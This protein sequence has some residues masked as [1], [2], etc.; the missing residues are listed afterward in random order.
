MRSRLARLAVV[1]ALVGG[2]FALQG[3]Q[4]SGADDQDPIGYTIGSRLPSRGEP[5]LACNFYRIDLKTGAATQVNAVN[6][7]VPCGDGLTFDEDRTLYAYR[8]T[9]TAGPGVPSQLVTID[10]HTGAQT[11]VGQL[12]EV[13]VG[14]GGMTFDADGHLWLYGIVIGD[15]SCTPSGSYCLYE[16][17]K[18]TAAARFVGQAP[19]GT[20]VYGLAA[21]CE[22]VL[23]ITS[24]ALS[25]VAADPAPAPVTAL[26]EVDTHNGA[27]KKIADTPGI[28]FP[29]GLDFDS[30]NDLWALGNTFG[31]GAGIGMQVY[32]VDP[33]NGNTGPIDITVNG[34]PFDGPDEWSRGFPDQ[35][36]RGTRDDHHAAA[37]AGR[38]R[39]AAVHRLTE[40]DGLRGKA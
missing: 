20:G 31:Q 37:R 1:A 23:A 22:D 25:G 6:G 34:V 18:K 8:S 2:A 39:R 29:T 35:W 19:F 10:K 15:P 3:T 4:V 16:V 36:L 17:N 32:R 24:F 27:L 28:F 30:E 21:D 11:L 12:P 33:D 40:P 5:S 7:S 38:R 26:N 13:L 14:G 9:P